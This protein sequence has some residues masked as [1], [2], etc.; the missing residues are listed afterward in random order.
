MPQRVTLA[1]LTNQ[2]QA[3]RSIN[4]PRP[5][6]RSR[7][8]GPSFADATTCTRDDSRAARRA[9]PA[10]HRHARTSGCAAS[11]RSRASSARSV[12]T[13]DSCRSPATSSG[14]ISRGTTT[15]ANRLS[16]ASIPC[17]SMRR[18]SSSPSTS[19]RAIGSRILRR[20]WR[21]AS[22][23]ICPR[24]WS[25]R[26]RGVAHMCGC[27]SRKRCRLGSRGSWARTF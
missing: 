13:G 5:R 11:A 3:S 10:T 24:P 4:S 22:G 26:A 1:G 19:T 20:S 12:R 21:R 8:S 2:D 16:R 7:C 18:A 6:R 17:C 23:W 14:G 15:P 27:F 9:S 25:G